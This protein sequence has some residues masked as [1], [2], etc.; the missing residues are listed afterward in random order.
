VTRGLECG[1]KRVTSPLKNHSVKPALPA[2]KAL[3]RD[4]RADHRQ[5]SDTIDGADSAQ[6]NHRLPVAFGTSSQLQDHAKSQ[7]MASLSAVPHR[8]VLQAEELTR[9]RGELSGGRSTTTNSLRSRGSL[10]EVGCIKTLL[11]AQG[12]VPIK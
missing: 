6:P 12:C 4:S 10:Q 11:I 2:P 1:A 3:Q 8:A 7:I 9:A 5:H